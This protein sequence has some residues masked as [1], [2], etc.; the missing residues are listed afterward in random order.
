MEEFCEEVVCLY[1]LSKKGGIKK[2][3]KAKA[4]ITGT[5]ENSLKDGT[6]R[7]HWKRLVAV[8]KNTN[9]NRYMET[10][11]VLVLGNAVYHLIMETVVVAMVREHK[12]K[13]KGRRIWTKTMKRNTDPVFLSRGRIK[14]VVVHRLVLRFLR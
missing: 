9:K 4:D 2:G 12:D 7:V 1:P 10:A 5:L 13:D 6:I 3:R 11:L 14:L 8:H